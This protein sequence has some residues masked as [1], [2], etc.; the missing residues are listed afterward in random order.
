MET[1][2]GQ[3]GPGSQGVTRSLTRGLQAV[4][5]AAI[6]SPGWATSLTRFP[7]ACPKP[8]DIVVLSPSCTQHEITP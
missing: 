1:E 2:E 3:E 7:P 5:T 8:G 4:P 6:W